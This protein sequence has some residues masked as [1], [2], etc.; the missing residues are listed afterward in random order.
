MSLPSEAAIEPQ[1]PKIEDAPNPWS[2]V[3][4]YSKTV[5]TIAS[6]FLAVTVSFS[7]QLIGRDRNYGA[8]VALI[9]TWSL[10][11]LAVA[12]GVAAAALLVNYLRRGTHLAACIRCSNLAFYAL[13]AAGMS[14]LIFGVIT[15]VSNQ[16]PWDMNTA[17]N[18]T[19]KNM[20]VISGN[21]TGKWAI[22]SFNWDDSTNTYQM[23]ITDSNTT[24]RFSIIID[25]VQRRIAKF[26]KLN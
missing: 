9:V 12:L 19:L 1:P 22:Q 14:F 17:I 23:V 11:V 5:I 21:R 24:N 13:L 18:E 4:D 7:S 10:L 6:G 16:Q 26:E 20:P 8:I 15:L 2:I 3:N 25:A